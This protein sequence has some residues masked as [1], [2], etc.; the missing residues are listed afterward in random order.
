MGAS[1][2]IPNSVELLGTIRA[3]TGAH[4]ATL[5]RRVNEVG[6]SETLNTLVLRADLSV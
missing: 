6:A 4:F 5:R 1:N 3:L 2:V